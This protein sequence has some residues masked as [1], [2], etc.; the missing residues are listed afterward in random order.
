MG[1]IVTVGVGVVVGADVGAGV[2]VGVGA[3]VGVGVDVDVGVG[4]TV[5]VGIASESNPPV[6]PI[7]TTVAIAIS[8]TAINN[9]GTAFFIDLS[10]PNPPGWGICA[11]ASLQAS[12]HQG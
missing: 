9:I 2:G 7:T 5:G 10:Y 3:D 4:S 8:R 1:V 11:I 12:L 6:A